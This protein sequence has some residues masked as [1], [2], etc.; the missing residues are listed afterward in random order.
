MSLLSWAG[1]GRNAGDSAPQSHGF[2]WLE[3]A[4]TA[5]KSA[6]EKKTEESQA[7]V[8]RSAG[9]C[10]YQAAFQSG[11]PIEFQ[12]RMHR[13]GASFRNAAKAAS[14]ASDEAFRP[15]S[16]RFEGLAR[17]CEAQLAQSEPEAVARLHDSLDL[18]TRASEAA[19]KEVAW[20]PNIAFEFLYVTNDLMNHDPELDRRLPRLKTALSI[21]ESPDNLL[22]P[23]DDNLRSLFLT[24]LVELFVNAWLHLADQNKRESAG[25]RALQLFD[26]L[27]KQVL[28]AD[29]PR[30][31]AAGFALQVMSAELLPVQPPVVDVEPLRPTLEASRDKLAVGTFLAATL[32]TRLD[33]L[34]DAEDPRLAKD[35]L[36]QSER[37]AAQASL[38]LQAFPG[39]RRF[40]TS[41]GYVY[42]SRADTLAMYARYY[43]GSVQ[44]RQTLI[45][46]AVEISYQIRERSPPFGVA[47][48]YSNLGY[49]LFERALL[50]TDPNQRRRS[51]EEAWK[52]GLGY[53]AET[54][55]FLPHWEFGDADHFELFGRIRREQAKTIE[56]TTTALSEA[57]EMFQKAVNCVQGVVNSPLAGE[58]GMKQRW[59]GQVQYELGSTKLELYNRTR[60]SK[61]F[62]EA[63][64]NLRG[65]AEAASSQA[66]PTRAGEA[67]ARIGEAY[68]LAGRFEEA[69]AAFEAAERRYQDA[70]K[71]YPGLFTVLKARALVMRARVATSAAEGARLRNAFEAA[72]QHYRDAHNSLKDATGLEGLAALYDGWALL[73][74]AE[75]QS[76]IGHVKAVATL[77]TAIS[78]FVD[79]ERSL[80]KRY[81][82]VALS[83]EQTVEA[84]LRLLALGRKYAEARQLLEKARELEGRGEL[85]DGVDRLEQAA[86]QFDAL[87]EFAEDSATQDLMRNNGRL[88]RASKLML[89]AEQ[90]LNPELYGKAAGLFQEAQLMS[91]TKPLAM[92]AGGWAACCKALE[93]GLRYREST[94]RTHFQALKKQLASARGYFVE[95]GSLA[96]TSWL[97]ATSCMFDAI[98]HLTEA[99]AT[100]DPSERKERY[101]Q[102]EK[103]L[104]L[105]AEMFEK[106]GYPARQEDALRYLRSTR[107][108][109]QVITNKLVQEAPVTQSVSGLAGQTITQELL[110]SEEI[111][112]A[113]PLHV[114]LHAPE[115]PLYVGHEAH[116]VLTLLNPGQSPLR[117]VRVEGLDSPD[118]EVDGSL[119]LQ[120][121]RLPPLAVQEMPLRLRPRRAGNYTLRP[122]VFFTTLQGEP[123]FQPVSEVVVNVVEMGLRS[124]LRG[125]K[126]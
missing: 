49:Y 66:I 108:Q 84:Q 62:E 23:L 56:D 15:L 77:Q 11:S 93:L 59:L 113:P 75:G 64:S 44:E 126:R 6:Q 26:R 67:L 47:A 32:R 16:L 65:S 38:E 124:W 71:K 58:P 30:C 24:E 18:L 1:L 50:E 122:R 116:I 105:A 94:D 112:A 28:S 55:L 10:Y 51:L 42:W 109:R 8:L 48:E 106:A 117:L 17:Y 72:A 19:R 120:G 61:L 99:E 80:K 103:L 45:R 21:V 115:G 104:L 111:L 88:C 98:A 74:E 78:R 68:L 102:A 101:E 36:A 82:A 89:Q 2:R 31:Q 3:E 9:H 86:R 27:R 43:A 54:H 37:D 60:D 107:D 63:L 76:R 96:I 14:D 125:P 83:E 121:K 39:I 29:D 91:K 118:L 52:A 5:E 100:L 4:E 20:L 46:Q 110:L 119:E 40:R 34:R 12:D 85:I 22:E 90:N 92:A 41:A 97:E 13:A 70:C 7:M 79:A 69:Q 81:T 33:P 57:V 114:V 53:Q 95:S 73:A 25:Q 35:L 87:S 123:R